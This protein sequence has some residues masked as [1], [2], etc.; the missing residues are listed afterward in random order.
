MAV[1]VVN[2]VEF[3]M[4]NNTLNSFEK[5]I[6]N[7]NIKY[8]NC[9]SNSGTRY[10]A[11]IRILVRKFIDIISGYDMFKLIEDVLTP[12]GVARL[13]PC[14][15]VNNNIYHYFLIIIT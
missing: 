14:K 15:E 3:F 12:I 8:M 9:Y 10:K 13:Y 2:D 6:N 11:R 4:F 7:D 5:I 1:S